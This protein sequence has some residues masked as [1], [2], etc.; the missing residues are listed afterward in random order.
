MKRKYKLP[1]EFKSTIEP[2]LEEF[3]DAFIV[4]GY[5]SGDH[6]KVMFKHPG[7]DPACRDGLLIIVAEAHKWCN[8]DGANPPWLEED[9]ES[10]TC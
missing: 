4:V 8:F 5:T 9:D 10:P 6:Q 7:K 2:Q 3:F 1:S